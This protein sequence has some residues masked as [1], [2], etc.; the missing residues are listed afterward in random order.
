MKFYMMNV[1]TKQEFGLLPAIQDW[2]E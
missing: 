1:L 2:H